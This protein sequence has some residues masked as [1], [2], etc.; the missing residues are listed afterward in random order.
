MRPRLLRIEGF[1][2]FRKKR[3]I[4]FTD[5]D[6][7]SITGPNG[8]G[9]SSLLE[10]IIFALYGETPRFIRDKREIVSQGANEMNVLFEFSIGGQI[11]RVSRRFRIKGQPYVTI[12]KEK[13]GEW[14]TL[15]EGETSVEEQI[16]KIVRMPVR[17]FTQAVIIPQGRFDV[18]LKPVRPKDRTDTLTE[19]FDLGIYEKMRKRAADVSRK[20][21]D[22]GD[23]IA[24]RL[25]GDLTTATREEL[26]RL[27]DEKKKLKQEEKGLKASI[28]DLNEKIRKIKDVVECKKK[29]SEQMEKIQRIENDHRVEIQ[30]QTK[31]KERLEK[32]QKLEAGK[33]TSFQIELDHLPDII[34]KLKD[35][36]RDRDKFDKLQKEIQSS[37]EDHSALRRAVDEISGNL[38][39]RQEQYHRLLNAVDAIPYDENLWEELNGLR[40]DLSGLNSLKDRNSD[41]MKALEHER[42]RVPELEKQLQVEKAQVEARQ[43]VVTQWEEKLRAT[44][45]ALHVLELR[46]GL[47]E[48]EDCPVCEAQVGHIQHASEKDLRRLQK[49]KHATSESLDEAKVA[50]DSSKNRCA[51]LEAELQTN[52]HTI[53]K[54]EISIEKRKNEIR[55]T[56]QPL[57]HKYKVQTGRE[58]ATFLL[59]EIGKQDGYR[60]E[61]LS[62]SRELDD[63]RKELEKTRAS[64]KS[65][66]EKK[67][68]KE[69]D[70]ESLQVQSSDLGAELEST[71]KDAVLQE[72]MKRAVSFEAAITSAETKHKKL[73]KEIEQIR[74]EGAALQRHMS[75]NSGKIAAQQENLELE[76]KNLS[77]IEEV[78]QS[79]SAIEREFDRALLKKEESRL[80]EHQQKLQQMNRKRGELDSHVDLMEQKIKEVKELTARK[81][82]VEKERDLYSELENYL[83]VNQ[84]QR[85]VVGKLLRTL[86]ENANDYLKELTEDKYQLSVDDK[87]DLA[88][89]DMWNGGAERS[90]RGLSGGETFV[91]SLALA[92]A[93]SSAIGEGV[94]IESLFL[95]EGFG[96]LDKG[97][98]ELV[99]DALLKLSL[100]NKMIGVVTHIEDFAK[101]FPAQL[102]VSNSPEGADIVRLTEP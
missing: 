76:R 67:T 51:K 33:I 31:V 40:P 78:F 62:V 52:H 44:D 97:R 45:R 7:F 53:Q 90:T 68:Q 58:V 63:K 19:M 49:D 92:L 88:V 83:R 95:D 48:G 27:K 84:L 37:A 64:L 69:K 13:H 10:A 75:E 9:K 29:R 77:R 101:A 21:R 34:R 65:N 12:E 36:S 14:S 66:E 61:H 46:G 57:Y 32:W 79:F 42:S 41:E 26:N 85:Y 73:R 18:F 91:V 1:S 38:A 86:V 15:G 102:L 6:I 11:F 4:D 25:A 30:N 24:K 99:R 2:S 47:H 5:L 35:A 54:L 28:S 8:A 17:A 72:Y 98:L 22:E 20:A 60:K 87:E 50:L 55:V 3:E 74:D 43:T 23:Q 70:L 100:F 96:N 89:R 93:L 81:K 71:L 39:I 80:D 59:E 56:E 94:H 16:E 82:E